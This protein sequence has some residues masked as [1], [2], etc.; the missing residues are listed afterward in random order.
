VSRFSFQLCYRSGI[1]AKW[2]PFILAR[3]RD[4]SASREEREKFEARRRNAD[5]H[6]DACDGKRE[7]ERQRER[8]EGEG[9][10]PRDIG[11]F[12]SIV[13]DVSAI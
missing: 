5:G 6:R 8:E 12:R 1:A 4:G 11:A 3:G 7:K 9:N 13:G 10:E 2:R